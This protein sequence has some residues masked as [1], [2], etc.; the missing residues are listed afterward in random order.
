VFL[1]VNDSKVLLK[2]SEEWT[3]V[4]A[5]DDDVDTV[6]DGLQQLWTG[7][8]CVDHGQPLTLFIILVVR[9]ELTELFQV[10]HCHHRIAG[11]LG[12]QQLR[13]CVNK[14]TNKDKNPSCR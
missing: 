6:A 1:Q 9:A 4:R 12:V 2:K 10:E 7:K 5:V 8:R 3:H 13:A 14:T 11:R